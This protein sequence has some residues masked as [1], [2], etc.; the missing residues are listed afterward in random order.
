MPY[1][2]P[3]GLRAIDADEIQAGTWFFTRAYNA[4]PCFVLGK[5]VAVGADHVEC[6]VIGRECID[7]TMVAVTIDRERPGVATFGLADLHE[8]RAEM[9]IGD[10]MEDYLQSACA[11]AIYLLG[12]RAFENFRVERQ[13]EADFL[14]NDIAAWA[15]RG[16]T[17]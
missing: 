5:I 11:H 4:G 3:K 14:L 10:S 2:H 17:K 13:Q 8:R 15:L 1:E 16:Q 6:F 9:F 7:R 12:H